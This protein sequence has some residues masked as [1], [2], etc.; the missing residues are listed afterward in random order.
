MGPRALE[1]G[2]G[3]SMAPGALLVPDGVLGAV[4][5]GVPPDLAGSTP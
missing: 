1:D 5:M 3:E 4:V 2:R